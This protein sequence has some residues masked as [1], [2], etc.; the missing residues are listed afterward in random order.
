MGWSAFVAYVP[1]ED[2]SVVGLANRSHQWSH[3]EPAARALVRAALGDRVDAPILAEL[4]GRAYVEAAF[5]VQPLLLAT[6]F[7]WLVAVLVRGPRQEA[8]EW[9]GELLACGTLCLF[10]ASLFDFYGRTALL[11]PG[12]VAAVPIGLAL[13]RGRLAALPRPSLAGTLRRLDVR[14]ELAGAACVAIIAP[15]ARAWLAVLLASLALGL[16]FAGRRGSRAAAAPS[17][18]RE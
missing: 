11:A 4:R 5:F 14:V 1:G 7:A 2:L 9:A 15:P 12:L 18:T 10:A 13:H 16:Y 6:A 3:V 8:P 17:S